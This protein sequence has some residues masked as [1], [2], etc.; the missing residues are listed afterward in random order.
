MKLTPAYI[1]STIQDA[2]STKVLSLR[3]KCITHI[4]DISYCVNLTKIDLSENEMKS[5][6]ALSGL[7]YCKGVTWISVAKNHL[8]GITNLTNLKNLQGKIIISLIVLK[9][10]IFFLF[11]LLQYSM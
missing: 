9:Y 7:K 8:N 1:S 5:G 10:Y 2:S 3:S 6:E 4:D 11:F